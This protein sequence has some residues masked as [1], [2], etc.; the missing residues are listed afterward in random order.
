MNGKRVVFGGYDC[1]TFLGTYSSD[2]STAIRLV[3]SDTYEPVATATV[4]IPEFTPEVGEV[5]IKSWSE[6][7]GMKES[8]MEY[9]IIGNVKRVLTNDLVEVTVHDLLI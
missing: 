1:L 5:L 2:N 4:C 7:E 9:G 3:D 6:N 8:L